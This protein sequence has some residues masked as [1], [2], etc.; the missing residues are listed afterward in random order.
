[1]AWNDA[2]E[3]PARKAKADFFCDAEYPDVPG[4]VAEGA[5]EGSGRVQACRIGAGSGIRKRRTKGPRD[6]GGGMSA[7]VFVFSAVLAD[8]SK[9]QC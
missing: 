2:A 7:L 9:L 3:V 6:G 8:S 1:M 5:G 4:L